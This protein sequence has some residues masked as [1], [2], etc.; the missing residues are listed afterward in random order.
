MKGEGMMSKLEELSQSIIEGKVKEVKALVQQALNEGIAPGDA[1]DNGLMK[2]MEVVGERFAA[3]DM[4]IPEVM[5][6]ARTMHAALEIL[7]PVLE[8]Q[9]KKLQMKGKMILGTVAGDI[10][11][12]GKSLVE[13]MFTASGFEV[14]DLG[15]NVTPE[16]FVE[17]IKKNEPDVIGMSAL[18]T[19]T[20]PSMAQTVTAIDNAGLRKDA[21]LKIIVGGAPVTA[22]F[23]EEIGADLYGENALEAVDV[24]KKALAG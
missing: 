8:G 11:D 12:I 13:M 7:R 5:L 6:S 20:M 10:H 15:I 9:K 14:V 23:A 19:S 21:R 16:A 18:L 22:E 3:E 4:F 1:L 17:A 2:G 24:V